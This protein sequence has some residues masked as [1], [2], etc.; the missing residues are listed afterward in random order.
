MKLNF[1]EPKIVL[2]SFCVADVL[3]TSSWM[4]NIKPGQDEL[5]PIG[6]SAIGGN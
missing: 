6:G 1:E 2:E 4:D 5:P 3:T